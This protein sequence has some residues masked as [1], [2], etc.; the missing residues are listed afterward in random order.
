M[1][2]D[3]NKVVQSTLHLLTEYGH[4]LAPPFS[5]AKAA[6][7]HPAGSPPP[8]VTE[9]FE[10]RWRDSLPLS[11]VWNNSLEQKRTWLAQ[12]FLFGTPC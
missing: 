5:S 1:I 10:A 8:V 11:M 7:A 4:E 3:D 12:V 9:G 2:K 6:L